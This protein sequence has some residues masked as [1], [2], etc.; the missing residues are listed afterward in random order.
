MSASFPRILEPEIPFRGK[1]TYIHSTD[2]YE[3][4]L[5]GA[6]T[7][8]LGQ[9]DGRVTIVLRRRIDS[10]PRFFFVTA[11]DSTPIPD[12]PCEF[13]VDMSGKSYKGWI[14]ES[15]APIANRIPYDEVPIRA[16][17]RIGEK[18][19]WLDGPSNATAIETVTSLATFMHDQLMPAPPGTKWWATRLD[20]NRPLNQEDSVCLEIVLEQR[21]G[22]KLTRSRV[23]TKGETIGTANFATAPS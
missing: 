18:S 5:S 3:F 14:E 17:S 15:G 11:D 21:L 23:I 7:M 12:S 2:I 9:P 19:I 20:F 13:A 1:R 8:K 6:T 10:R 16:A 22:K 4:V